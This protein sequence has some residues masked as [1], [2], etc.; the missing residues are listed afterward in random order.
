MS[1]VPE[2]RRSIVETLSYFS[3]AKYP[4]TK[5]ELFEYL[6]RPPKIEELDYFHLLPV[7]RQSGLLT[8]ESGYYFLPGRATGIENRRERDL[9]SDLKIKKAIQ[10]AKKIRAVPFLR[11]IFVC[12]SV[13]AGQA[14]EN[15]DIDFL[16]IT[17]PN[18][19]W[20]VRLFANIILRLF[21]LRTYGDKVSDKICLSF[22][23][24]E[25]HLNL[26]DLRITEADIHFVY[27]IKQ[28]QPIFDPDNLYKKFLS[29]NNWTDYYLPNYKYPG[30]FIKSLSETKIGSIWRKI[31]EK[32][33]QGAYGDLIEKE[34]KETQMMKMS[35]K[36]KNQLND[37]QKG[38]VIKEGVIKLHEND[39]RKKYLEDWRTIINY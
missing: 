39:A 25:K 17:A 11:A 18:R 30:D 9:Q 24:D 7:I 19:I 38:V 16:I 23:L 13:G 1:F 4:L 10:A 29:I 27:W 14:C 5:E 8:E 28:M 35:L 32:M 37:G 33:W 31:C 36:I 12:N 3:M 2:L 6:W 21:G 20:I 15:S 22:F 26:V 34:A